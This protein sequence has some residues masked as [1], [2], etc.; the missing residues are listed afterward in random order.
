MSKLIQNYQGTGEA[1]LC[2]FL[3]VG[4]LKGMYVFQVTSWNVIDFP[5]FKSFQY[6]PNEFERRGFGSEEKEPL[7]LYLWSF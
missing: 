7:E 2:Q 4:V 3:K 1:L 6:S 5:S